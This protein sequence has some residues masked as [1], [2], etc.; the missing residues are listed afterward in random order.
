MNNDTKGYD[1]GTEFELTQ[2]RDP[3]CERTVYDV[4]KITFKKRRNIEK[5]KENT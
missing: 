1:N 4:E 3:Y 5:N 2:E